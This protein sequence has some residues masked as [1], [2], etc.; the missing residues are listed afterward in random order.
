LR[1]PIVFIA[2]AFTLGIA[3]ENLLKITIIVLIS[4]LLIDFTGIY[5]FNRK[6][7]NM[8]LLN[9]LFIITILLAGALYL[10]IDDIKTSTIST[11]NNQMIS[12]EGTVK[13][14]IKKDD[15]VYKL[16]IDANLIMNSEVKEKTIINYYG[17]LEK[18][19][20]ISDLI[21]R[22]IYFSGIVTL[23][24]KR[25]NPGTFDYSLY[26]KSIGIYSLIKCNQ[27]EVNIGGNIKGKGNQILNGLSLIK[28]EMSKKL[29]LSIG[30][31]RAGVISGMMWGEKDNID[32]DIM[33][34]FR[35]NGTAHILAVSGIHVGLVY[36][37]L[38]KLSGGRKNLSSDIIIIILLIC[39][40]AMS[41][42]SPSVIRA[43]MM[44]TVHIVSKHMFCRYDFLSCGAAT[45]IIMLFINPYALFNVGF[46]LSFLAIFSLAVILPFMQKF[47]STFINP[48]IALQVG[49]SPMTAFVFNYFSLSSLIGNIPV[50]FLASLIIP[51]GLLLIPLTIFH[52]PFFLFHIIAHAMGYLTAIMLYINDIIYIPGKSFF[53]IKSPSIMFMIIYYFIIFFITSELFY[54][55][56]KREKYRLIIKALIAVL[57]LA[58]II[59][60]IIFDD[61]KKSDIVFVDV[62]QGDCLH[63]KTHNGENIL[64]D[65]G[66]NM[67]YD[68]GAKILMPYLLKNGV[69]KIDAAF[70]THL[71]QDHYGGV[72][73]LAKKGMI[74]K[75]YMYESN[76]AEEETIL[77]ETGLNEGQITYIAQ[78][79][80]IVFDEGISVK[81]LSPIRK[82]AAYYEEQKSNQTDENANSL[83]LKLDYNGISVLMTGDI[84]YNGEKNLINQY[85][86]TEELS[87]NILKVSHHGSKNG[88]SD[89]FLETLKPKIAVI[90]VGKN[91]FGHPHPSVIEKIQNKDIMLYRNDKNGAIGIS[92]NEKGKNIKIV[93]MLE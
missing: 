14:A 49:L 52:L 80:K 27:G 53:Y 66:G 13:N 73:T 67:N 22:E 28:G 31:K 15:D 85:L 86:G 72:I 65:S 60:V 16:V 70:V 55:L 21:G 45:L 74:E 9:I 91:N 20:A 46:Q 68:V 8:N 47:C 17:N 50:I 42:F 82:S 64:I 59:N 69:T 48:I 63:I 6:R 41:N 25:R 90:Q 76:K 75:L 57:V 79:D 23:P 30:G 58:S 29:I 83:I 3:V 93:T 36:I 33:E 87:V 1:R 4:L 88:T 61:F 24:E 62:G 71:H 32:D 12:G 89:G 54:I 2:L 81:V 11:Y 35:M 7:N 56:Y 78:G 18:D 92:V 77:K 5:V 39:Y 51:L 38:N 44:I 26:L 40:A 84:D 10:I 34:E 19:F 43:V 37:Y